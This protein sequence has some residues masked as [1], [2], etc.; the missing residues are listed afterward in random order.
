MNRSAQVGR[1]REAGSHSPSIHASQKETEDTPFDCVEPDP[2]RPSKNL[3][4]QLRLSLNIP[5]R[6]EQSDD[7]TQGD[8]P[9]LIRFF[10][11]T[12]RS[13]IYQHNVFIYAWGSFLTATTQ[14]DGFHILFHVH[15]VDW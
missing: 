6:D 2:T 3:A 11:Q 15:A 7:V 14:E 12:T 4:L 1:W 13:E 8:I 10:S 5:D 9:T